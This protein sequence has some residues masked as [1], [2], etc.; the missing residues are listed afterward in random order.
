M[1]ASEFVKAI[2]RFARIAVGVSLSLGTAAA[3]TIF[4]YSYTGFNQVDQ[5]S[6]TLVATDNLDGSFTAISGSGQYDGFAITLILNPNGTAA[7]TSPSGY[8]NYDNQL[9]PLVSPVINNNGLL[10]S[11]DTGIGGETELNVFSDSP[12]DGGYVAYLN[13]DG[14]NNAGTFTIVDPPDVP[15]P[16]TFGLMAAGLLLLGL[17]WMR[18]RIRRPSAVA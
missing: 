13:G 12:F 18:F 16:G 17:A 4:D 1:R 6:G 5:A 14:A 2:L 15:E 9:F 7:A 10:F 11:I 3:T 8:F